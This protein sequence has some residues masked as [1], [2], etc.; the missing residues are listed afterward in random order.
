MDSVIYR[1]LPAPGAL[2]NPLKGWCS[3]TNTDQ[4]L[5]YAMAF[6]YTSWRDLEPTEGDFRF[7]AWEKKSWDD[8]KT[9][10]KHIVLRV[11]LDYPG[12]PNGVPAW[13]LA[14]GVKT[15][16][17]T[18][19]MEGYTPGAAKGESPDYNNP[20]MVAA[21]EKLIAAMGK[22]YDKHPQVAFVQVGLLGFWGEWHTYPRTEL[23]ASSAT[24]KRV[25][26]AYRRAFPNKKLMARY[27]TG[28]L[29]KQPWLGFHDD[30]FPEDTGTE[31]DWYFLRGMKESGRLGNWRVAPVG[32]EMIPSGADKWV[33]TDAGLARTEAM[34]RA[35]HFSWIGPYSP[36]QEKRAQ[37]DAAFRARCEALVRL[38]GYSF[39]LTELT[40]PRTIRQNEPFA[41]ALAGKNEGVAPFYYP[42][43]VK[44]A[45]LAADGAVVETVPLPRTDSRTWQPGAFR[46]S[47]AV[48]FAT[49]P[50]A[51]RLAIG[52]ID[53]LTKSP[54]IRFANKITATTTGWQTIAPMT[55]T[56]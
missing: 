48:R 34:I 31:K 26:D 54:A 36:A 20:V 5:S 17:Y 35:A 8:A 33:G 46:V 43:Q 27:A 38:M 10:G 9:R 30:Y 55:L 22:R 7:A 53:P 56:R 12:L 16:P 45:L 4:Y 41:L 11:Y 49:K 15:T 1:L 14:K 18:D 28:Y 13:L 19:N 40:L 29:G 42:W 25:I 51:Y 39:C 37:T 3:Y 52:I 47:E 32:G 2:D 21:L 24:Q 50:G 23:F 44:V 6:R